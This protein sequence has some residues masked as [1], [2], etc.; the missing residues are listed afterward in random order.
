MTRYEKQKQYWE[1]IK[2][3]GKR[4]YVMLIVMTWGMCAIIL[5]NLCIEL[6]H[7]SQLHDIKLVSICYGVSIPVFALLG[8]VI[9]IYSWNTNEKKYF[10]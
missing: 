3:K 6:Y 9:G 10:A 2:A 4:R 5:S 7:Q 1:K 8:L